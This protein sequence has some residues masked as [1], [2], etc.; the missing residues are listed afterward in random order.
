MRT[1]IIC[2]DFECYKASTQV[3]T[4]M[5]GTVDWAASLSKSEFVKSINWFGYEFGKDFIDV[6][7]GI[8][9]RFNLISLL[10]TNYQLVHVMAWQQGRPNQSF[11]CPISR[12]DNRVHCEFL[13]QILYNQI[14]VSIALNLDQ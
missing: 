3:P 9:G 12:Y 8:S 10:Y 11:D 5:V 2:D 6:A 7:V 13:D 1:K 4:F 14:L